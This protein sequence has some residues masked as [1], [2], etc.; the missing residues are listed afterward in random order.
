MRLRA[1]VSLDDFASSYKL[2]KVYFGRG[3]SS[4]WRGDDDD[5]NLDLTRNSGG[6]K[7]GNFKNEL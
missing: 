2:E 7:R 3:K 4:E 1:H 6:K 5:R